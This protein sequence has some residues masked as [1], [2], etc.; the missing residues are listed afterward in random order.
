MAYLFFNSVHA[1]NFLVCGFLCLVYFLVSVA[2]H[3]YFFAPSK[4]AYDILYLNLYSLLM[5]TPFMPFMFQA[6]AMIRF[7]PIILTLFAF[8]NFAWQLVLLK[9]YRKQVLND[10][11]I[12]LSLSM[13]GAWAAMSLANYWFYKSVMNALMT[14]LK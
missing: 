6:G 9:F 13:I 2:L 3:C 14:F 4:T 7:F 1:A 8:S 5:S 11:V 12:Y 10:N